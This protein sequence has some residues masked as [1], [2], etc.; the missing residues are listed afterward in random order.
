MPD[1]NV[2]LREVVRFSLPAWPATAPLREVATGLGFADPKL[3]HGTITYLHRAG[4]IRF[5]RNARDGRV[6]WGRV[7]ESPA[8]T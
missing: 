4:F 1:E 2:N 6:R 5:V 8:T 3:L 7:P